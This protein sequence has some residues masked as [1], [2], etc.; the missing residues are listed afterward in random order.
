MMTD[1]LQLTQ[2]SPEEVAAQKGRNRW[3]G[4]ALFVFVVLVG[5]TTTVR[6]QSANLGVDGGFY[7]DGSMDAGVSDTVEPSK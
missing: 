2:R 4:L 1:E 5:V 3:L 7:F 6:L